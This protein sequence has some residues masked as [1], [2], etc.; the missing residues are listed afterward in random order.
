[1]RKFVEIK[2]MDIERSA[3]NAWY[4]QCEKNQVPFIKINTSRGTKLTEV[5][6]DYITYCTSLDDLMQETAD[7]FSE[8]ATGI[9]NR[10]AN[11]RSSCDIS[12]NGSLVWFYNLETE[13]ARL[14]ASELYDLIVSRVAN[15]TL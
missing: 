15:K 2:G 10:Y 8:A 4:Q 5:H 14:A 9:F 12:I 7:D 6:W 3:E 1:M 11:P 13:K